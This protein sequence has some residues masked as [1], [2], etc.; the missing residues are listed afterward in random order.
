MM[1]EYDLNVD[2]IFKELPPYFRTGET[3]INYAESYEMVKFLLDRGSNPNSNE[4]ISGNTPLMSVKD[5]KVAELLI[6]R[7]ANV[8]AENN[9]AHNPLAYAAM[10]GQPEVLKF[11]INL[12][13]DSERE[14]LMYYLQYFEDCDKEIYE[15]MYSF[16]SQRRKPLIKSAKK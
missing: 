9:C 2:S 8:E 6:E 1:E 12:G 10:N 15:D 16:L 4:C 13:L 3:A 14:N 7:G 5:V 11:F